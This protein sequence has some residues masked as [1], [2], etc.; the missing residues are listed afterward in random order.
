MWDHF[1]AT[2]KDVDTGSISH[3]EGGLMPNN[4]INTGEY[5]RWDRSHQQAF[6]TELCEGWG[7]QPSQVILSF[8]VAG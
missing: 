2:L 5:K 6:I 4:P 1:H 7:K 3:I 8:H